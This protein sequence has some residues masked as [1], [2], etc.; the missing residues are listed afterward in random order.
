MDQQPKQSPEILEKPASWILDPAEQWTPLVLNV[1]IYY[2]KMHGV[3]ESQIVELAKL[4][5]AIEQWR[6][7]NPD[8]IYRLGEENGE[9]QTDVG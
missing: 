6:E 1:V 5:Q 4:E 2:Y 8:K 9:S 7:Q 3:P